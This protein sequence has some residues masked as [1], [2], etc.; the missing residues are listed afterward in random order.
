[1]C[2]LHE[3]FYLLFAIGT[4]YLKNDTKNSQLD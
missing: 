2:Q 3:P 4:F 1:L